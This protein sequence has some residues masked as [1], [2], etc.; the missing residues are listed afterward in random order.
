MFLSTQKKQDLSEE[1]I[2]TSDN[3]PVEEMQMADDGCPNE[4]I[5]AD[6]ESSTMS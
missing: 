5:G 6:D 1:C 4:P 2:Q 3:L